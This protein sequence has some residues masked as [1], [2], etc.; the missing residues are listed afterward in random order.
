MGPAQEY[1][2]WRPGSQPGSADGTTLRRRAS[3]SEASRARPVAA[4]HLTGYSGCTESEQVYKIRWV[5]VCVSLLAAVAAPVAASNRSEARAQ[6]AF[7]IS[8]AQKGLWKE[9][10]YRWERAVAL[11]PTYAAAFNNLA[12]AYEHEGLF[13]KAKAAYETAL[14]LDPKNAFIK[15]NFEFFREINDRRTAQTPR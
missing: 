13:D 5:I 10:I 1:R 8:V 12:I 14:K 3:S 2:R 6:V 7:G 11:D 4:S 15:Q 9:A